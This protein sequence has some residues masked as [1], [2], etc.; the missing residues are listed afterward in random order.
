MSGKGFE[1]EIRWEKD[2]EKGKMI[3]A[4][5]GGNKFYRNEVIKVNPYF[6]RSTF[7]VCPSLS[8]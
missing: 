2:W 7:A 1:D 4:G 8:I 6:Y 5:R 3:A